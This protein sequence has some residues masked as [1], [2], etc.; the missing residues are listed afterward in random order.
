MRHCLR[1][2]LGMGV[3]LELVTG[4]PAAGQTLDAPIPHAS[5]QSVTPSFEGWYPNADGTFSLSFGYMN[6]NYEEKLDIQVGSDNRF[7]PG[8]ADRGQPTHFLP[9]RHTGVFTIVVP[10]DFSEK[11]L[12][13]TLINGG[14]TTSV[15]GHLRPEWEITALEEITSGNTPPVEWPDGNVWSLAERYGRDPDLIVT[16]TPW[17]QS[18]DGQ[19]QW[20]Q[21][22]VDTGLT[23][24]RWVTSVE[25]K[26]SLRGRRIVH[27]VVANLI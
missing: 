5:G 11:Q 20:Y 21:P 18:P 22:V 12:T 27:H 9:R 14:E 4:A 15:P 6:R 7:A 17:T 13:W 24:D 25:V 2:L 1:T 3:V 26:P 23:E 10:A 16:S 8:V 19:D